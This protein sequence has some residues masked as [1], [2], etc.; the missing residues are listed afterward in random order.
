MP[1][2]VMICL[3]VGI[4]GRQQYK[5]GFWHLLQTEDIHPSENV[6]A[7]LCQVV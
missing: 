2:L 3:S 6:C 5:S 4:H 7:Y 1:E